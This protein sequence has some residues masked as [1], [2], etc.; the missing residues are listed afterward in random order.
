[1][2][3]FIETDRLF[4]RALEFSDDQKKYELDSDPE[5]Q[6]Y[7]G[8]Q[9]I[10]SIEEARMIIRFIRDQY[11]KNGIGRLAVVDKHSNSFIGWG[12]FKLITEETNNHINYYDLGY[13]LLRKNWGNG[14]ATE[15]ARGCIE[16]GFNK[17]HLEEIVAIADAKN[18]A[19]Q[20]VLEKS[21][22]KY[23]ETFLYDS[24][25]HF[26][27]QLSNPQKREKPL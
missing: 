21:G 17:L 6:R 10:K 8:N 23:V 25:P 24:T 22:F 12:G 11:R 13:R 1:M 4:L 20:R 5:V 15:I 19:S 18:F 7:C 9:P 16:F 27:F 26:W 14:Y 3:L 2:E